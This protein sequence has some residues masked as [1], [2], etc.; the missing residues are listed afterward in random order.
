MFFVFFAVNPTLFINVKQR[1]GLFLVLC[2]NNMHICYQCIVVYA[3]CILL[4]QTMLMQ[5]QESRLH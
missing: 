1:N 5:K 4:G 2:L 3:R